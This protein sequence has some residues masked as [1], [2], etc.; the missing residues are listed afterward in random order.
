M[1]EVLSA[2]KSLTSVCSNG[3]PTGDNKLVLVEGL[4]IIK[5]G[6]VEAGAAQ[7][8]T[9]TANSGATRAQKSMSCASPDSKTQLQT[10]LWSVPREGV[11]S[12]SH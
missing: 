10:L 3:A 8:S 1:T 6:W 4:L 2:S 12:F 11:T 5:Q 7:T 9:R